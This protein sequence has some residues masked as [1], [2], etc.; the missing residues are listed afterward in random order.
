V[1]DDPDVQ[2]IVSAIINMAKSLGMQTLAEGVET[3]AQLEILRSSG[4]DE[5]QGY[6]FSRPL[7]PDRFEAIV[8]ADAATPLG[9]PLGTHRMA[10]FASRPTRAAS[11]RNVEAP[12][13]TCARERLATDDAAPVEKLTD[14]G[15]TLSA[16]APTLLL[17]RR[18]LQPSGCNSLAQTELAFSQ[19]LRTVQRRLF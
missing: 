14:A 1:T 10:V 15:C 5:I 19:C 2:A 12:K 8:E 17:L 4:C 7:T 16:S 6:S 9:V 11:R 18:R 13:T 3:E